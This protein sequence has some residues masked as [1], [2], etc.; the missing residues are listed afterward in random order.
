MRRSLA[1]LTCFLILLSLTFLRLDVLVRAQPP[2]A[3]EETLRTAGE[4]PIDIKHIRLDLRVDL[5]GK[6][7]D[8]KATLSFRALHDLS[9]IRL[10]AVEFTVSKVTLAVGK[11][12]TP[13]R[14]THDGKNLL[15]S[16]PGG[17]K[18]D[19]EGTLVVDYK[20]R[21]PQAGLH[22]FGPTKASPETPLTVW[23]QGE[24]ITNRYWIPCLDQPNQRQ[25]T[26][27]VV[28]VAT[29]NEVLSNGKLLERKEN[30]DKTV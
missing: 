21:E 11:K 2:A 7:V 23:S 3:V 12:D 27:L 8:G 15:V 14:F 16:V 26:E 17:I 10:D 4:R 5:P 6:S 1:F 19:E 18:A 22:F 25:S 29:G 13:V 30:D 28:T 20:V 9:E 24:P